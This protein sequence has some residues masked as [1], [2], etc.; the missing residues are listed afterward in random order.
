M[1]N[2]PVCTFKTS[3]FVP[4]PRACGRTQQVRKLSTLCASFSV[5]M[6]AIAAAPQNGDAMCVVSVPTWAIATAPQGEYAM[7]VVSIIMWAFPKLQGQVRHARHV[8]LH[9]GSR[10]RFASG[11][12][13]VRRIMS[14]RLQHL[15]DI[16]KREK[17]ERFPRCSSVPLHCPWDMVVNG[18]TQPE[19]GR[20]RE[21][22]S[23]PRRQWGTRRETNRPL[24]GRT[25]STTGLHHRRQKRCTAHTDTSLLTV[26]AYRY[27]TVR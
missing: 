1:K 7:P 24:L 19:R 10:A 26:I 23:T 21:M 25:L 4:A 3:P 12:R 2:V 8:C 9:K 5:L 18:C 11:L 22:V 27:F 17:R 20:V 15:P 14:C 16:P 13:H 6:W